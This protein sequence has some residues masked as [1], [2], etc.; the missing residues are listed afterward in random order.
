MNLLRM[1]K[2]TTL[3]TADHTQRV[4]IEQRIG[5][6]EVFICSVFN[7]EG[8]RVCSRNYH[9]N[10][11]PVHG[12]I[13]ALKLCEWNPSM[14]AVRNAPVKPH[15]VAATKGHL[16]SN[17]GLRGHSVGDTFPYIV[18]AKGHPDNLVWSVRCPNGESIGEYPTAE[19]AESIALSFKFFDGE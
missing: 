13:Y 19:Y 16:A 1:A 6:T 7:H 8:E 18:F 11:I 12:D 10:G 4:R 9:A 2:G 15:G 17:G 3:W 14:D 5:D